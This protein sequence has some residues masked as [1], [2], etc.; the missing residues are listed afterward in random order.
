[1]KKLL[2]LFLALAVLGCSSDDND[3]NSNST[4]QSFKVTVNGQTYNETSIAYGSGYNTED[5]NGNA[6]F[7]EFLPEIDTATHWYSADISHFYLT[8]DFNG[9]SAGSYPVKGDYLDNDCNLTLALSCT[10]ISGDIYYDN[11]SNGTHNVT[12]VYQISSDN[13]DTIWAVEGNFSGTFEDSNSGESI[14][15]TGS[16]RAVLVT[17][18]D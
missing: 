13:N 8:S 1:M 14:S 5:C 18:Q 6:A 3:S 10:N 11:F 16:Y 4:V 7:E 12:S 15:L 9:T 2:Y 17:Y